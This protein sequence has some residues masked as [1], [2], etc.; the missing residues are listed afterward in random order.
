MI[1]GILSI[2]EGDILYTPIYNE[3][4][5]KK[6]EEPILPDETTLSSRNKSL[7]RKHPVC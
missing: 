3:E 4:L 7:R 6:S 5:F 1:T 2:D